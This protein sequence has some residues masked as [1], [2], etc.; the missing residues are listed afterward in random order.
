MR[1]SILIG[2]IKCR[3]FSIFFLEEIKKYNWTFLWTI[4]CRNVQTFFYIFFSGSSLH[5]NRNYR[6]FRNFNKRVLPEVDMSFQS[7]STFVEIIVV[8]CFIGIKNT[9]RVKPIHFLLRCPS[10]ISSETNKTCFKIQ[11]KNLT[12]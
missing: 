8:T 3:V 4:I 11:K 1:Y 10:K 6:I 5:V 12:K 2:T 7:W 9:R